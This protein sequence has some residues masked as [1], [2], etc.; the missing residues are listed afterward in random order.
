MRECSDEAL[1]KAF[2]GGSMEAF[3][4]LY[5]RHRIGLYRYVLRK[6]GH[7]ATAND[8]FQGAWEKV[9]RARAQY[10]PS[11]PFRAWLYRVTYNHVMD[12]F[13]RVQPTTGILEERLESLEPG[14]DKQAAL[15]AKAHRLRIAI[16]Q[17]PEKQKDALL[18][19]L[20]GGLD[21]GEIAAVTGVNRE[22]AKS[23]LRYATGK[24]KE[25]LK[26]DSTDIPDDF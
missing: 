25:M 4:H 19:K 20:E 2:A 17:L 12:Y 16:G 5:E 9:V 14:P 26:D 15:E 18:L 10:K 22:T 7:T 24:L 8:L 11:T 6:T 23:R 21:L 13:R 3:E 1:M